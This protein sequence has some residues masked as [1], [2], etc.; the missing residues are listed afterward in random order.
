MRQEDWLDRRLANWRQEFYGPGGFTPKEWN[1]IKELEKQL[2]VK[3]RDNDKLDKEEL[4]QD[5]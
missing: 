4:Q 1:R 3:G 2:V 5:D